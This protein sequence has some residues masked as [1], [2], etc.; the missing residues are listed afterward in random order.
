MT[1]RLERQISIMIYVCF[2][3][4]ILFSKNMV[5]F[6]RLLLKKLVNFGRKEGKWA[7]KRFLEFKGDLG[8]SLLMCPVER[9]MRTYILVMHRRE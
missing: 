8:R 2:I 6:W 1:F 4:N 3:D 7:L 5:H 9:S